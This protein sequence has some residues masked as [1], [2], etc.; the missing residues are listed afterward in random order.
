MK[1]LFATDGSEYASRTAHFLQRLRCTEPVSLTVLTAVYLPHHLESASVNQ[2]FPQWR[3]EERERI[4]SHHHE[5][6]ELFR[7]A[8][9]S[10]ETIQGDGNA[11]HCILQHAER[12]D[13]DL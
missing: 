11:A 7:W 9:G 4:D 2:W 6:T 10:V 12:L 3:E 5:L 8:K 1:I 13:V